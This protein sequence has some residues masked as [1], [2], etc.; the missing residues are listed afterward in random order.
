M[1]RLSMLGAAML[2]V[3]GGCAGYKGTLDK[4]IAEARTCQQD[5]SCRPK[6]T[7][8]LDLLAGLLA[9][10][11][12]PDMYVKTDTL[13][14]REFED[15]GMNPD[16]FVQIMCKG[17]MGGGAY[18]IG[19]TRT[20][21]L[22]DRTPWVA[23]DHLYMGINGTVSAVSLSYTDEFPFGAPGRENIWAEAGVN[24]TQ[25]DHIHDPRDTTH[26]HL[27]RSDSTDTEFYLALRELIMRNAA[28]PP[29]MIGESAGMYK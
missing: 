5:P 12:L 3:L 14:C 2:F 29:V 13:W 11:Q 1:N 17:Q 19:F 9:H 22:D 6:T 10:Y 23:E 8:R 27:R 24:G 4:V 16:K 20:V 28:W 26:R 25:V 18:A 15:D 7:E 21:K